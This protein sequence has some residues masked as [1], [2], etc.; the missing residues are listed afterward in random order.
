M[1]DD[2]RWYDKGLETESQLRDEVNKH[3]VDNI[4]IYLDELKQNLINLHKNKT[5]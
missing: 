1:S 4:I 2:A 5:P 3:D